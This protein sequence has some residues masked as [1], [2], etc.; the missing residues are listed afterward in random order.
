MGDGRL[1]SKASGEVSRDQPAPLIGAS[2]EASVWCCFSPRFPRGVFRQC[3][4]DLRP[5]L[6]H[7]G[8][9]SGAVPTMLIAPVRCW[10]LANLVS[11][12]ALGIS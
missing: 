6:P 7:V 2:T 3:G 1:A 12:A 10:P 8:A 11:V 5:P 9:R 4:S